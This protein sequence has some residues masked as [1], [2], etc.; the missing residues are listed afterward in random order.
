MDLK[1]KLKEIEEEVSVIK[2]PEH[3]KIA[4][5]K[6]MD[7]LIGFAKEKPSYKKK[8]KSKGEKRKLKAKSGATIIKNLNLRPKG[9]ISFKDFVAEKRPPANLQKCT[10]AVYHLQHKLGLKGIGVN[11]VFTC[12]KE[13]GWR[14]PPNLSN[15]LSV[16]AS[17]RGWLD[18]S[19]KEDIKTTTHGENLVEHDLPLKLKG[20]K[21]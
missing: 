19:N 15:T 7:S 5:G 17:I 4:F 6:L 20:S 13:V 2:D 21:K 8:V 1:E 10:V 3:R 16:I 9:K 12:Y 11:H 14:V 18:T